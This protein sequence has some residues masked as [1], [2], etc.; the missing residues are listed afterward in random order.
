[1]NRKKCLLFFI[2]FFFAWSQFSNS[3]DSNQISFKRHLMFSIPVKKKDLPR[4]WDDSSAGLAVGPNENIYLLRLDEPIVEVFTKRGKPVKSF[5]VRPFPWKKQWSDGSLVL[6]EFYF[7]YV[8]EM[9]RVFIFS[10]YETE[11]KLIYD[12][13]GHDI[14]SNALGLSL[15]RIEPLYFGFSNGM[16]YSRKTGEVFFNLNSDKNLKP[17]PKYILNNYDIKNLPQKKSGFEYPRIMWID[18]QGNFYCDYV[19]GWR[20]EASDGSIIRMSRHRMLEFDANSNLIGLLKW[21]RDESNLPNVFS[22]E[23]QAFYNIDYNPPT[24]SL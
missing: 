4:Y 3:K 14:T 23:N 15:K 22:K 18:N 21:D 24:I 16:G 19:K 13:N 5:S 17:E 12:S 9:E 1:M 2:V 6:S 11:Y 7:L 8:D 10:E 20:E